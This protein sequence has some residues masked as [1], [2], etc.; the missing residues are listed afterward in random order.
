MTIN[1]IFRKLR[2][3]NKGQ[4]LILGFCIF[5]SVLL[6]N[7]FALMYY[8]P[9]VQ[10][11][12]PQG[13]DTRKMAS[14]LIGVTSVGCLI[15][16][17][18]ASGLFFRFKSREFGIFLA[19]GTPKG[20]LKPVLFKELS[21]LVLGSALFGFLVS[22]PVSFGIWKLFQTFLVSTEQMRYRFG[23][24]GFGVGI[25]FA[26]VLSLFLFINGLRFLKKTN[27]MDILRAG[28]KTEMVHII[29]SWTGTLGIIMIILGLFLGTGVPAISAHVFRYL[30]PPSVSLTYLIAL[31]GLYLFLLS[32]VAQAKAERKKS[33]YYKNLVNISMMRFT[34]KATT[35]SM[36]VIVLLLLCSLFAAFFGMLYSD[37]R[38][39]GSGPNTRGFAIHHPSDEKQIT[40]ED[41]YSLAGACNMD[42]IDYGE[43]YAANLVISYFNRD[44]N[45]DNR[46]ITVDNKKAKLAL[47]LSADTYKS[48]TGR[49]VDVKPG[50]YQTVTPTD[51]RASI[52]DIEDGLYEVTNPDT[53]VSKELTYGGSV[54]FDALYSMS[55]PY[56]YVISNADYESLTA[57]VSSAYMERILL[58]DV[59][60]HAASYP[61]ASALLKAY[62]AHTTERSNYMGLYDPWEEKLAVEK[63]ESYGYEGQ[64]DLSMD[65]AMLLSDWKYKPEF[66]IVTQQD[67]LQLISVYVMLCL[68]I[69]IITLAT[70]AIMC[71][72]RSIAAATDN[73]E[74]FDSLEKLG[75]DKSY[76]RSILRSQLL[77]L[78]LYPVATGC[79]LGLVFSALVSFFNDGYFSAMEFRNLLFLSGLILII[80]VS[81]YAVYRRAM[82]K[83]EKIVGILD[84]SDAT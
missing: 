34:A 54:E 50:V 51:Y 18:Y 52:F 35:R 69:F 45:D 56:T 30:M 67:Y 47:F 8:S 81:L 60:D 64:F 72:V 9:T 4:Y 37:S 48:L 46:Y 17:L 41:I 11:F 3:Q 84:A 31:A 24:T 57:S 66:S 23:F 63:G 68:Y 42:I 49:S 55:A 44:I 43:A 15:F 32:T 74:L 14:L 7:S 38:D 5:L 80:S 26:L 22:V 13:G 70:V 53:G 28:H 39:I 21:L 2:R 75:A 76:S 16:T 10:E 1:N 79:G 77:H 58:F 40:K 83:A 82:K 29:P 71:Y 73:R 12:L 62:V 78:F 27:I 61:F 33:R 65:N 59:K 36:C 25:L 19:M 6:V 20:R